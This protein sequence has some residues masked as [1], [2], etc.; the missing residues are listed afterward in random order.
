MNQ[1]MQLLLKKIHDFQKN[2]ST[3]FS[4]SV[5]EVSPYDISYLI[6]SGYITQTFSSIGAYHLSIT[7]TGRSFV[8][9]GYTASSASP[10]INNSFNFNGNSFSN[11]VVGSDISDISYTSNTGVPF[12]ELKELIHSKPA[13]DQEQLAELLSILQEIDQSDQPVN[14]GILIRFSDLLNKYSDLI[15]PVGRV[16]IDIFTG[17]GQ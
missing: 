11:S 17:N 12:A 16:L 6:D 9:N 4:I 7:E 13:I 5:N 10:Q 1:S 14:K 8:E 15:V 3:P 2:G